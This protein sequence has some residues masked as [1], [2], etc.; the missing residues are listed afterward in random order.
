MMMLNQNIE[1]EKREEEHMKWK[2]NEKTKI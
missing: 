1:G 2:K